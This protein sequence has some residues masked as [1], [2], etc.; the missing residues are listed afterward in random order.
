MAR[1]FAKILTRIW[2]DQDWRTLTIHEQHLYMHLVTRSDL[3]YAGVA[4]WR[5]K[6]I[7]PLATN[8]NV[9]D[10]ELAAATLQAK[11]YI[12]VDEDTEEVL[13]RS[14]HR[15]D[16]ALKIANMGKAVAKAY[17]DV[18]SSKLMGVIV[19]ELQRLHAEHPDWK[20]WAGAAEI[21]EHPS[22]DPVVHRQEPLPGADA[23]AEADPQEAPF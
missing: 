12:V 6:R 5:P 22:H 8:A 18:A 9:H 3:S 19:W 1:D 16:E 11:G 17:F 4:D 15:N 14:Y 21:L 2:S 7:T 20:G 23:P 13:V 10:I